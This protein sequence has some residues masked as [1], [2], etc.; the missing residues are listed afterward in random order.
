MPTQLLAA[1]LLIAKL[2]AELLHRHHFG[3]LSAV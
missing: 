2:R 3:T 1:L